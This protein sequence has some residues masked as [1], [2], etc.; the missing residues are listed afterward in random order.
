MQ[1]EQTMKAK[2]L[3]PKKERPNSPLWWW[4]C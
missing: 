2:K 1:P 3:N 4:R